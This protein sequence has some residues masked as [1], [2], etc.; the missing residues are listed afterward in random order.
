MSAYTHKTEIYVSDSLLKKS[1]SMPLKFCDTIAHELFHCL[2]RASP[3]FRSKMYGLIGFT[4]TGADH[5]FSPAIREMILAN[6]D[7]EHMDNYATFT[8]DGMKRKCELIVL[9]TKTWAEASAEAGQDASFFKFNESV[10]VPID[11]LDTYYPVSKVSDFM[12][13]MGRNTDYVFAPE[14]C[15]ADNFSYAVVYGMN[16]RK[17]GTP[18]LIAD[19]IALLKEYR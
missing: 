18:K 13:V 6:P 7:V 19:I 15:L 4:V 12:D 10:L 5:A 17:Y 8:I 14:E 9:Y 16:G 11:A 1:E 3:S 2:T